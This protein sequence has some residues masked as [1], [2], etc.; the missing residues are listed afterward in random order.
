[1]SVLENEENVRKYA[2]TAALLRKTH[3]GSDGGWV[4]VAR[5]PRKTEWWA[6]LGAKRVR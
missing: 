3:T 5:N 6:K 2:L 1:M 4:A